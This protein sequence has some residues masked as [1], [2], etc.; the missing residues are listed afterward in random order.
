MEYIQHFH[1]LFNGVDG[2]ANQ[3]MVIV[4]RPLEKHLPKVMEDLLRPESEAKIQRI[5]DNQWTML[6][7]GYISPAAK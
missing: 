3:N 4:Q 6:R 2:D 5:L 7:Q 1:H